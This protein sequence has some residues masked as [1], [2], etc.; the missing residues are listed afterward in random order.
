M[1]SIGN[2]IYGVKFMRYLISILILITTSTTNLYASDSPT[3]S[4]KSFSQ[5]KRLL[6]KLYKDHRTTFYCGCSYDNKKR[7]DLNSCGYTPRKNKKRAKR[8]EWEHVVPAHQFGHT[9][10][11]WRE[12]ICTKKNGKKY[13]G[14]RCC[15]KVDPIFKS[16][17]SDLHNLVPAIGEVNGDRSNFKFGMLEGERRAYGSCD[18]EINFKTRIV[19]PRPE[20][21]GDIA[22]IYFYMNKRYGLPISKKQMKLFGIWDRSDPVDRWEKLKN[23]RVK[24]IQGDGNEFVK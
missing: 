7:I 15:T 20:I 2:V 23:E 3:H 4:V 21:R 16:M 17:A 13:K 18:V 14:R 8:L 11:C 1:Y 12:K 19:E 6:G 9:R 22:R 10:Q 24:K 5:A